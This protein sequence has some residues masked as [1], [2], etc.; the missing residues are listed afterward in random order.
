MDVIRK[1][2]AGTFL[3]ALFS[4]SSIANA[5]LASRLGGL[6][7]YDDD[8]NITWIANA[9]LAAS[10]TFGVSGINSYGSMDWNTANTWIDA[11]NTNG[12]TGYLGYSDWRLPTTI[13]P[14]AA[15]SDGSGSGSGCLLSEMGHLNNREGVHWD[16]PSAP[17]NPFINLQFNEYW[18]STVVESDP[19][20]SWAYSFDLGGQNTFNQ[21]YSDNYVW[22]V[23]SGDVST[24][25][26][27]A[28]VW[29]FGSGLIGLIGVAGRKSL[30]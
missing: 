28:A 26:V 11:M 2:I 4:V 7:Y 6:A 8:L 30:A 12:G 17:G 27:P 18:S 23:R 10:N 14:D 25:P 15:C 20:R 19:G 24:A 21:D 9:N 1:S 16:E 22:A 5:A 3:L 13:I 29:L